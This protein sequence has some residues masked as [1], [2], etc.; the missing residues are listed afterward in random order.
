MTSTCWW[1]DGR[2]GRRAG[3]DINPIV[4]AFV[5]KIG[6]WM[7]YRRAYGLQKA[8]QHERKAASGAGSVISEVKCD[9]AAL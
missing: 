5:F 8:S 4:K 1:C 2:S 7:L 6:P 3:E 9:F